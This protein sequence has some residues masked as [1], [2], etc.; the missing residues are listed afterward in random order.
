MRDQ[1]ERSAEPAILEA[2]TCVQISTEG[3]RLWFLELDRHPERYQFET[4]AG[5]TFTRG[6]FG[7]V[8]ARFQTREQFCGLPLRLEFELTEVSE[9][10]FRFRLVRPPL[11]V[12]GAFTIEE[13]GAAAAALRLAIGSTDSLGRRFLHLP[14]VRGAILR[15]IRREVEHIQASMEATRLDSTHEQG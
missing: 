11:P 8:G 2:E 3:A 6:Q 10:R 9:A 15:Q 13:A 1:G 4:H 14:L 7:E 12:W 5:F